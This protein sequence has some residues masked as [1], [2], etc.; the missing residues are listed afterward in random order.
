MNNLDLDKKLIQIKKV[1]E[2][3]LQQLQIEANDLV[4]EMDNNLRELVRQSGF[5]WCEKCDGIGKIGRFD[6]GYMKRFGLPE[7]DGCPKCGGDG[8]G[9]KG[10]GYYC[11]VL[12]NEDE[13]ES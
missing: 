8:W 11:N 1:T 12:D 2:G 3:K 5:I 6:A 7:W 4:V 13:V 10:R 9:N